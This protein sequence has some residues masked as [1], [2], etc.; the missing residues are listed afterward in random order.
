[1]VLSKREKYIGVG[2]IAAVAFLGIYSLAVVPY[3][4]QRDQLKRDLKAAQDTLDTNHGLLRAQKN[5]EPEWN[6]MLNNGLRAD[7]S[8]ARNRTQ[9]MLQNWARAAGINLDSISAEGAP[10]QKGPFGA[11][12]FSLDFNT[13]GADSMRQI[14]RFLWSVESASIPIRLNNIRI[15]SQKE[16][17]DQL[18]V[19]LVVSALYMPTTV[20]NSNNGNNDVMEDLESLQ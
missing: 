5:R 6:T 9:Q 7:D 16:G 13:A 1:V 2:T 11:I 19:K 17:S 14:S 10:S 18:N 4:D 15:Q 20:Q 8:T 3:F 12:N